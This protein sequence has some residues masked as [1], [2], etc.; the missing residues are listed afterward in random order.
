MLKRHQPEDATKVHRQVLSKPLV[1][2]RV[3][4]LL[5]ALQFVKQQATSNFLKAIGWIIK[6]WRLWHERLSCD[7]S[8]EAKRWICCKEPENQK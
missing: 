6:S 8:I 3:V 7:F 4:V 2:R 5:G 1:S